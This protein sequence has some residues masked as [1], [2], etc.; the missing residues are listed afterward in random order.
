MTERK[1]AW[2]RSS[3]EGWGSNEEERLDA[4]PC[5]ARAF[6]AEGKISAWADGGWKPGAD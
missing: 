5:K 6:Q 3:R 2:P 4:W 1:S